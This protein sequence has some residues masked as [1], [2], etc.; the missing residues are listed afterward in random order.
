MIHHSMAHTK[1]IT[2]MVN[3]RSWVYIK[4]MRLIVHEFIIMKMGRLMLMA[5][6]K[7]ENNM[8]IGNIISKTDN[9]SPS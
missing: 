1:P 6:F 5:I 8:E 9:Y 3:L 4:T 2:K 7:T